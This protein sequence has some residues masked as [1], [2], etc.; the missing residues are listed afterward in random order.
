MTKR[1]S[2]LIAFVAAFLFT[3]PLALAAPPDAGTAPAAAA[4]DD[5]KADAPAPEA[6]AEEKA[7]AKAEAKAEE[8]G[9]EGGTDGTDGGDTDGAAADE[10]LGDHV[11]AAVS[12]AR[13]GEWALMVSAIIML[14]L[15][16]GRKFGVMDKVPSSAVPWV[17]MVLGV[18]AVVGD[19]LASGGEITMER[20]L[21]G[22]MAGAAASGLWGMLGKHILGPKKEKSE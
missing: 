14:L 9:T 16:A 22:V 10:K 4:A 12:A 15:G 1:F 2:F 13:S 19:T 8:A 21:A 18:I 3:A 5:A 6:K 17:S 7:E 20:V 11:E